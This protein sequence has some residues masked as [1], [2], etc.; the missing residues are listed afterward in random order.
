[1]IFARR[2]TAAALLAFVAFAPAVGQGPSLAGPVIVA[3][4]KVDT[5]AGPQAKVIAPTA[6]ILPGKFTTLDASESIGKGFSWSVP[7]SL[8]ADDYQISESG[9]RLMF[10]TVTPGEYTFALAVATGDVANVV[11]VRVRV[12]EPPAPIPPGPT[13]QPPIPTPPPVGQRAVLILRESAETTPALARLLTSLRAG[14]QAAYLKSKGH[15]LS[16]L[17]DDA[18]DPTGKPSPAVESW[19]PHFAGMKLPAVIIYDPATKSILDKRII[20][21]TTTAD[22]IIELVKAAGG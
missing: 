5:L 16:I 6:P 10:A 22:G 1:M 15:S 19:R 14:T 9:T 21:D 20:V 4:V 11:Q 18:V 13:P 2:C 8:A 17:D 7:P 3:P 12:G